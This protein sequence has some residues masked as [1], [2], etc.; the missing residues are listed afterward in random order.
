MADQT[1]KVIFE[2]Q[3]NGVSSTQDKLRKGAEEWAR[4]LI[5][6]A[7]DFSTSGKEVIKYLEE[8]IKLIERRDQLNARARKVTS[9]ADYNRKMARTPEYMQGG[10]T[11]EYKADQQKITEEGRLDALQVD[12]LRE[13]IDTVKQTAREEI[14]EDRKT[15]EEKLG[16]DKSVG[17]LGIGDD[18]DELEALKK[19]LQY[20]GIGNV[21]ESETSE[22]NRFKFGAAAGRGF[23]AAANVGTQPNEFF[24]MAAILAMIP[25]VGAGLSQ[26]GGKAFA[27]AQEYETSTGAY[28]GITGESI[29]SHSGW[30]TGA[31]GSGYNKYGL[32]ASQATD[33]G[34]AFAR[35]RGEM[36][37]DFWG[38]MEAN[39]KMIKGFG[40]S[41][42][43]LLQNEK[44]GRGGRFLGSAVPMNLY[45]SLLDQNLM[46]GEDT[47]LLPEYLQLMNQ[48]GQQQIEVLGSIDQ[49]VNTKMI[50]AIA[51]MG[52]SMANPENLKRLI[53]SFQ[54][55][56]SRPV[57]A[58]VRALQLHT[59]QQA[60][61]SM[62]LLELEMQ[63]EKGLA[64]MDGEYLNK[65][66]GVL[67]TRGGGGRDMFIRNIAGAF[68]TSLNIAS[69]VADGFTRG[70][71]N[72]KQMKSL[73]EKGVDKSGN[74][75]KSLEDRA[76]G[77][78]GELA[79]STAFISTFFQNHGEDLVKSL[80][81][82]EKTLADWLSKIIG[83]TPDS[84]EVVKKKAAVKKFFK[85][86]GELAEYA[87]KDGI[88]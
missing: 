88:Q 76:T 43:D 11:K 49:G 28:G 74:I 59:L 39:T 53:P 60:N 47:S 44:L 29:A 33:R 37:P 78:T 21:K 71:L 30:K 54:Q 51:G 84:P 24:M 32:S 1:K 2:A 50:T 70:D 46:K 15:V 3:D 40:L 25:I 63:Q 48:L 80:S 86:S 75:S 20:E 67:K 12:L 77:N 62:S 9:E 65:F 45:S 73:M 41:E 82:I 23:N 6:G 68:G 18:E 87:Y 22:K 27:S 58:G 35:A 16:K 10:V 52:G 79:K 83:G 38:S 19:T 81:G 34:V 57:N 42:G 61:P 13:L 14:R 66:L 64:G 8:E 72:P 55:G 26:I 56:L 31:L 4:S 69:E 5:R 85:E 7:R 36:G 17:R